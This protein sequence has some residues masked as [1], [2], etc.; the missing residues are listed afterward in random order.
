MRT[1][2]GAVAGQSLRMGR[3][4]GPDEGACRPADNHGTSSNTG[5]STS[6]S[7]LPVMKV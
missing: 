6:V 1:G 4:D 7:L 5:T 3:E 2:R